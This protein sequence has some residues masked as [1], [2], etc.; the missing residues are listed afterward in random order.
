MNWLRAVQE[1]T[2]DEDLLTVFRE[3]M[4]LREA[5]RGLYCQ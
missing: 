2:E 3:A 4:Q 5:D 1:Y